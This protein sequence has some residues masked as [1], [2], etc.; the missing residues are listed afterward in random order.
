[1]E[2]RRGEKGDESKREL[3]MVVY[4]CIPAL[5]RMRQ[6]DCN[7][8]ANLDYIARPCHQKQ[9]GRKGG[10]EGG[11]KEGML[12]LQ[13]QIDKEEPLASASLFEMLTSYQDLWMGRE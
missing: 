5:W 7:I 13:E 10:T 1:M 2:S 8:E 6:E 12:K 4:V 3:G 11:R 9:E